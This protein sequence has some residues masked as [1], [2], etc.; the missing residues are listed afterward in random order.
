MNLI[1]NCVLVT[2]LLL[3]TGTV[4]HFEIQVVD[5][6]TGRGVP[7]VELRT[8]NDV[9]FLTD[10]GGYVA[11]NSPELLNQD[12][13]FHVSSHGYEFP[14]DGFGYHGRKLK[15][16]AG[17]NAKLELRRINI[18]ERLY[19]MTGAGIYRDSLMLKNP[20]PINQPLINGRVFGSDSVVN[21]V[22]R[23]Q[24]YWFWGDTNRPGYPLGNFHVPGATSRLPANGG[25]DPDDGVNLNYF[26]DE[27]GFAKPTAQMPGEGPT[28]IRGLATIDDANGNE[29]LFAA[30]VKVKPPMVVYERGLVRFDDER[31][32]F[33]H[34]K[35]FE[36]DAPL[37]PG[38]HPL[39]HTDED[40]SFVYF[41]Q[42][43]P[44]VRVP[45]NVLSFEDLSQYETYT[46]LKKGSHED[47]AQVQR[48][49]SGK[50]VYDWKPDT[51]PLTPKLE[52]RLLEENAIKPS[53]ALLQTKD[54]ETGKPVMLHG[55]SVYW[56]DYRKRWIMIALESFG[57]SLLGEIW[58]A[59]SDSLTGP[60]P[61]ARKIVTHEKYSF[62]NPKQHPMFDADQG[63]TIFFEGTYTNMF[64]GN[65]DRTPRYNYNQV[66]YKLDLTDPRLKLTTD[67][68]KD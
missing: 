57:T 25:L 67:K 15:V 16:V 46:Y 62:Y 58:Y 13:F 29:Q 33:R 21:A 63:R 22:Y 65:P 6:E 2:S 8:V 61:L 49:Q 44:L 3:G 7:L 19:R 50:L 1:S 9:R 35:R 20:V 18:A 27:N 38:G 17:G 54:I 66:M 30:Y 39:T 41:A 14:K 36:I 51:V 43:Y 53:E 64:S 45:E 32:Q 31:K 26:L 24:V 59:E 56:N 42:P 12:V 37:F 47:S 68:T 28:W 52:K 55:G 11:I 40:R 5:S 4:D 34:V 48:D 23:G 60:W 10:S